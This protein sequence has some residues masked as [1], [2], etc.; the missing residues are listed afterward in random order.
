M[1]KSLKKWLAPFV[2]SELQAVIAWKEAIDEAPEVKQ[3]PGSPGLRFGDNKSTFTSQVALPRLDA[4]CKVQL[5]KVEKVSKRAVFLSDGVTSIR[6]ILSDGAVAT[7]EHEL[8]EELTADLK[9]DIFS[10]HALTVQ[11][12]PFGPPDHHVQ[13]YVKEL[14][15]HYSLRKTLGEPRP[16]ENNG[17][18]KALLVAI[19]KMRLGG[20]NDEYNPSSFPAPNPSPGARAR[21]PSTGLDSQQ[22]TPTKVLAKN[23][24]VIQSQAQLPPQPSAISPRRSLGDYV[25]PGTQATKVRQRPGP[26]LSKDGFEVT[27]GVNLA[28]P[29]GATATEKK[30]ISR[31]AAAVD[32]ALLNLLQTKGQGE[33]AGGADVAPKLSM[34]SPSNP[35]AVKKARPHDA[36]RPAVVDLDS[37]PN[38]PADRRKRSKE[39]PSTTANGVRVTVPYGRRKIPKNQYR[40][41]V[42]DQSSWIPPLP[43]KQF[44]TPNIPVA[45]LQAWNADVPK[46]AIEASQKSEAARFASMKK[47]SQQF[48]EDVRKPSGSDAMSISSEDVA[49]SDN[50]ELPWSQSPSQPKSKRQDLPVD[51]SAEIDL[52]QQEIAHRPP[53]HA[54]TEP[55]NMRPLKRSRPETTGSPPG[56]GPKRIQTAPNFG[57]PSGSIGGP[58]G[59]LNILRVGP[60]TTRQDMKFCIAP[61][62]EK[63]FRPQVPE[64]LT[65]MSLVV[66]RPSIGVPMVQPALHLAGMITRLLGAEAVSRMRPGLAPVRVH[67]IAAAISTITGDAALH[68]V[69]TPTGL[70]MIRRDALRNASMYLLGLMACMSAPSSFQFGHR[71]RATLFLLGL[72]RPA[73]VSKLSS[74]A[75][76]SRTVAMDLRSTCRD[77]CATLQRSIV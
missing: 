51:S 64:A 13:L 50:E 55:A 40:L 56:N 30:K 21:A 19:E 7:L 67:H 4:D 38:T 20:Q 59:T 76:S 17:Q 16:I 47:A 68:L 26:S 52:S 54:P 62:S 73:A 29:S 8:D 34:D 57:T 5:L 24:T 74:K 41:A 49:S 12:T 60:L 31:P 48:T 43:G 18:V 1:A 35:S 53:R 11:S 42:E 25:A 10:L 3:E 70:N 75:L 39:P 6:A 65:R 63:D 36:Q 32:A 37:S 28:L 22:A 61:K 15:Y 23:N 44:P 45:L 69:G 72:R 46:A 71:T 33:R 9:G 27:A 58:Q 14:Q 66:H 77:H 2:A